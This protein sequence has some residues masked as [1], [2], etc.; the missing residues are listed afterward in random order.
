[1]KEIIKDPMGTRIKSYEKEFDKTISDDFFIIRLDG[2]GFSKFTKP[3][4]KPYDIILS[5]AMVETTIELMKEFHPIFGYTQ[6]DE[7]TLGFV[8]KDTAVYAAGRFQKLIS[9]S[10]SKASA[11]FNKKLK[12]FLSEEKDTEHRKKIRKYIKETSAFFDSRLFVLPSET[13]MFNSFLWRQ[14]DAEKN[15]KAMLSQQYFSQKELNGL[16]AD[17]MIQKLEEEKEILWDDQPAGFKYGTLI[18]KE[19]FFRDEAKRTRWKKITKKFSYS[20]EK[21]DFLLAKKI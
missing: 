3:F 8:K 18:K 13:E 19:V 9:L 15:S 14:R 2:H 11:I 16:K 20:K 17:E 4:K 21:V 1:M 7:I 10:S 6:S 5:Q 12:E